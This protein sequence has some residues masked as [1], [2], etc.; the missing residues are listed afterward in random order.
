MLERSPEALSKM[1][2]IFAKVNIAVLRSPEVIQGQLFPFNK[3][4]SPE[5]CLYLKNY[6]RTNPQKSTR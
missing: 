5:H 4:I 1:F 6:N 2:V 3:R